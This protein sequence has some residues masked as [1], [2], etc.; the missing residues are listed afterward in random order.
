[1]KFPPRAT[2]RL[3]LTGDVMTGRA[4]DQIL[5]YSCPARIYEPFVHSA[6]DYLLMA[7]SRNGPIPYPVDA[8]YVWGESLAV[9]QAA[10]P[11]VRI[12][13]LET[14]VTLSER[15]V[16]KG[17]NYRMHPGNVEVL[18]AASIDCCVLANNHVLDWDQAGLLETLDSLASAGPAVAGAGRNLSAAQ[19]PARLPVHPG[20][21][22]LV[23]AVATTDSGVPLSWSATEMRSGVFVLPDYSASSVETIARIVHSTKQPGDLAVLSIHWGDNWGYPIPPEQRTFAH[24]LIENADVDVI[25]GHSAHHAKAIEVHQNHLILYG[26]GDLINDYEGIRGHEEFRAGLVSMYF[27]EVAAETGELVRLEIQPFQLRN[28]RL[29]HP[30]AT[31]FAWLQERL[32]RE[33]E[34]FGRSV[35]KEG[36]G[37]VLA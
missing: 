11:D 2:I 12:I 25:Y 26:C 3:C 15:A 31:D 10:Q 4:I 14:S 29:Q 13:N 24:A 5:P 33:C 19:S 36:R 8:S 22:V 35:S 27:P 28:F 9:L 23:Y 6:Q 16:P 17:I 37:L 21:S 20:G 1:L 30:T 32:S 7:E 34:R 18:R